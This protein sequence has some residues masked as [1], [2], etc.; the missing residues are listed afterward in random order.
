M[1]L[2]TCRLTQRFW[3]RPGRSALNIR[4]ASSAKL[5]YAETSRA[6]GGEASHFD[7]RSDFAEAKSPR[8]VFSLLLYQLSYL[9][10]EKRRYYKTV[11]P[12]DTE[13]LVPAA[14]PGA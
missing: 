10:A 9:A 7:L 14:P 1:H 3:L 13:I 6:N 4:A 2:T 8:L 11:E 12:P 5:A